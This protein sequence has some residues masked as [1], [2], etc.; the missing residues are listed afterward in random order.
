[1][2]DWE[3]ERVNVAIDFLHALSV[4]H[5]DL[6]VTLDGGSAEVRLIAEEA[7][8]MLDMCATDAELYRTFYYKLKHRYCGAKMDGGDEA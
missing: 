6:T 2:F 8:R 4:Q 5:G 1:M 7:A 3:L